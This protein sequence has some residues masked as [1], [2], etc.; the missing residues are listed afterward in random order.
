MN[1]HQ[2]KT[3]SVHER[4][5]RCSRFLRQVIDT[6][7][8]YVDPQRIVLFGSRARG[9]E[10]PR[11]DYDIALVGLRHPRHW[12]RLLLYLDEHAETL[13]PFDLVCYDEASLALRC[14]IDEDGIVLYERSES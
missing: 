2:L 8:R 14:Q 4:R 1:T 12:S 7:I 10:R 13:L 9:V 3:L 5:N 11:S 6:A